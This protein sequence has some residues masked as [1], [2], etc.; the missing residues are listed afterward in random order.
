M[1]PEM[2]IAPMREELTSAGIQEAR[3]AADV[4]NAV[5]QKGTTMVVVNSVCGCAAGRMRPGVR[6]AVRNGIRPDRIITVF[7]GQDRDAT[8]KARSFFTGFAPSSPSIGLLRDGQLV[9]MMQR[10]DIEMSS[11]EMIASA[12][13]RAFEKHCA[14]VEAQ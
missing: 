8:E 12:L 4:E 11:P 5:K 2:M 9:Y 10:S 1:Y 14:K 3:T 13:A 6:A 7:A